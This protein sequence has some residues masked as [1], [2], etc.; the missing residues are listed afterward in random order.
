MKIFMSSTS[1]I[2]W[3]CFFWTALF[4]LGCVAIPL[5][6]VSCGLFQEDFSSTIHRIFDPGVLALVVATFKQACISAW[7]SS[8]FGLFLGLWVGEYCF[9]FPRSRMQGFLAVPQGIP[10]VVAATAWVVW[11]G[12][13]GVLATFGIH[14]DWSYTLKAVVLAH[15]FLNIP[16]IALSV[17]QSRRSLAISQLEV[18]QTLGA[19][20]WD[21]VRWLIWPQVRW[22]WAAASCQAFAFCVM[23]FGLV[24]ILGGGPPVQTLET[25]IYQRLRYGTADLSGA[26]IFALWECVLAGI[27]WGMVLFFQAKKKGT[28]RQ[29]VSLY[30]LKESRGKVW[31]K[32][33]KAYGLALWCS[34]LLFILP[35]FVVINRHSVQWLMDGEFRVLVGKPVMLSCIL[36][37]LS[38]WG[39]VATAIAALV[40]IQSKII[41][42][43]RLKSWLGILLSLPHGISILVLSLGVWL[44][45]GRWIDPF[46]GSVAAIVALQCTLFFPW[47]FRM[48]WPILQ[49]SQR[50]QVESAYLLG[51]SPLQAFFWVEWPRWRAPLISTF[52]GVAGASLGE[53]G[54]VSFFYSENLIPLPLLVSRGMQQYRFEEAQG[55]AGLLLLLSFFLIVISVE[56]GQKISPGLKSGLRR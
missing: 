41:R 31:V 18:A 16:L 44:A 33:Y 27:P 21:Q 15:A 49:T 55:V 26:T 54:A 47:A 1:W 20:A 37:G 38:G 56:T 9:Y 13:S 11:L 50:Q 34:V 25:A 14:L 3:V 45:Y 4:G 12:R 51:A 10:S 42:T 53:L 5:W 17:A 28:L 39:A 36:A 23:S 48:L 29:P 43:A 8:F 40:L 22:A 30:S 2:T 7:V 19:S 35:Y 52:A 24:L 32:K 46:E 6:A